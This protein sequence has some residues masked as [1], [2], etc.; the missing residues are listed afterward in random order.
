MPGATALPRANGE[1]LF[2][3]PWQGRV[4]GVAIGVVRGLGVDWDAFRERLIVA[5][6]AEPNRPYYESWTVALESLVIDFGLATSDDV[7]ARTSSVES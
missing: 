2:D 5:I 4:L 6:E 7:R 1:I 3:A